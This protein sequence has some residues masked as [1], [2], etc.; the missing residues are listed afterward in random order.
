MRRVIPEVCHDRARPTAA[1]RARRDAGPDRRTCQPR[2]DN[3]SDPRA[4]GGPPPATDRCRDPSRPAAYADG[5]PPVQYLMLN[6]SPRDIAG[7]SPPNPSP[8]RGP[9]DADFGLVI[10][11]DHDPRFRSRRGAVTDATR[12]HDWLCDDHGGGLAPGRAW[13]ERR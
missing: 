8:G 1:Q 2:L 11:V 10:G 7:A 12:F 13:L 5:V 6:S 9:R 3:R 4:V